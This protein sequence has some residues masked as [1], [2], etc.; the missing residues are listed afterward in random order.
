[1]HECPLILIIKT[2]SGLKSK[3]E[4]VFTNFYQLGSISQTPI[5]KYQFHKTLLAFNTPKRS[6]FITNIGVL[7][8]KKQDILN[9]KKRHFKCPFF[10][11]LNAKIGV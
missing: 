1:M 10:S 7:N 11:I 8:A 4:A 5:S 9:A 3:V 2:K 6:I